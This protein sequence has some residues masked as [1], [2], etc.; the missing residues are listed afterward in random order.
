MM[1][2]MAAPRV[3]LVGCVK[4]KLER[5][6]P[7]KDLYRSPLWRRRRQYAEASGC[8]WLILSAK[9]GLIDPDKRI[10]PYDLALGQLSAAQRRVWG[11]RVVRQLERRLG[12]IAGTTFELHAGAAYRRAIQPG[13]TERGGSVTAPLAHLGQGE[14]LAW[15]TAGEPRTRGGGR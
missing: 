11:E 13:I 14:Q 10:A 7:A 9:H 4:L 3:I 6:A 5:P 2:A 8:P 15:Y 12:R 1:G